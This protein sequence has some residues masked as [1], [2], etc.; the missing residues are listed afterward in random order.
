M[1]KDAMGVPLVRYTYNEWGVCFVEVFNLN[2]NAEAELALGNLNPFRYRGYYYDT[3]S[4]LY[5]LMSRYYDPEIGQFICPD[6]PDWLAPETIGGVDLYAYC[7]NNPIMFK[8]PTGKDAIVVVEHTGLPILG[9][10]AIYVQDANGRWYKT[11]YLADGKAYY[12]IMSDGEMSDAGMRASHGKYHQRIDIEGDFSEVID[13]LM[14]QEW[15]DSTSKV[16]YKEDDF[17]GSYNLLFN[18][19]QSSALMLLRMGKDFENPNVE[20]FINSY[21]ASITAIPS[22]FGFNLEGISNQSI[23]WNSAMFIMGSLLNGAFLALV[24]NPLFLLAVAGFALHNYIVN[25]DKNG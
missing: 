23:V 4:G 17:F 21:W 19:C 9:H 6:T 1:I 24:T 13:F 8:D 18:S 11:E 22:V 16:G 5:Y 15:S 20:K 2:N 7:R 3:E 12:K 14:Q 25:G 10:I